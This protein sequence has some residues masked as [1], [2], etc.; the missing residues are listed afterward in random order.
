MSEQ[1]NKQNNCI[2]DSGFSEWCIFISGILTFLALIWVIARCRWGEIQPYTQLIFLICG[3][4]YLIILL[5]RLS[6]IQKIRTHLILS[7][8]GI[9]I[10]GVNQQWHSIESWY[11]ESNP[12]ECIAGITGQFL[13][14]SIVAAIGFWSSLIVLVIVKIVR[15]SKGKAILKQELA[16][17]AL[18]ELNSGAVDKYVW[19][20]ALV[21][22]KGD[23]IAAKAEYIK[24][25][26]R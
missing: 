12:F 13:G 23:E 24:L 20:Q 8:L 2:A 7:V 25:R 9:I 19:A 6:K 17:V 21:I 16:V 5:C 1:E 14:A 22:A 11:F 3:I 15:R 18:E 4:I 26:A 10:G